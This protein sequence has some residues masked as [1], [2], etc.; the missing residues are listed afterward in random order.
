MAGVTIGNGAVIA[1]RS[2][3]TKDVPPYTVVAGNPARPVKRRFSDEII[4]KMEQIQ[5]WNW[6][7]EKIRSEFRVMLSPNIEAFVDKHFPP[8]AGSS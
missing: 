4:E 8:L 5:W 1:A 7:V 6:P 2:V 3:V